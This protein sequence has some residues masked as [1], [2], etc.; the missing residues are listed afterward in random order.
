V[1][2]FA[3]PESDTLAPLYFE[4]LPYMFIY[5]VQVSVNK[6]Q[7]S[8]RSITSFSTMSTSVTPQNFSSK[9][10]MKLVFYSSPESFLRFFGLKV[11]K[12]VSPNLCSSYHSN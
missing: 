12:K 9:Y 1:L 4:I 7:D 11:F 8:L 3:K 5:E 6:S 2:K 10:L